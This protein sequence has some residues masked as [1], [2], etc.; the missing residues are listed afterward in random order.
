MIRTTF[1]ALMGFVFVALGTGQ[2]PKAADPKAPAPAKKGR[3]TAAIGKAVTPAQV[4]TY[5]T[6]ENGKLPL[7]LHVFRPADWKASDKRPV[8]ITFHGGG[9]AAG[10]P[11]TQFY[12]ADR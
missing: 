8:L 4:I 9:W 3:V 5:K 11:S 7:T 10:E 1:A 12:M 2:E 6:V